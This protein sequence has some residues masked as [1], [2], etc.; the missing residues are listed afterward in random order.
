[1]SDWG[2]EQ[3]EGGGRRRDGALSACEKRGESK[4]QRREHER[5]TKWDKSDRKGTVNEAACENG[6]K[7]CV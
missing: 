5:D 3:E 6:R 4:R 1:M 7:G 2:G